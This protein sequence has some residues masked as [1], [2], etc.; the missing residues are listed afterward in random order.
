MSLGKEKENVLKKLM[1]LKT[2]GNRQQLALSLL[3]KQGV[4]QSK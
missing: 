2:T 4:K 1:T 3:R